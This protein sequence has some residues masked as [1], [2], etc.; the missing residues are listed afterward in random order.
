[1]PHDVPPLDPRCQI[2]CSICICG[3]AIMATCHLYRMG[4]KSRIRLLPYWRDDC[5]TM[6]R[7]ENEKKVSSHCDGLWF[8]GENGAHLGG[9]C[10]R[11]ASS[12]VRWSN[13]TS[14]SAWACTW[15]A[16]RT[17]SVAAVYIPPRSGIKE[18]ILRGPMDWGNALPRMFH[19]SWLPRVHVAYL[20]ADRGRRYDNSPSLLRLID[21]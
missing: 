5:E 6:M 8:E 12:S 13:S 20:G 1:M 21:S 18:G 17:T 10:R 7:A 15:S 2:S 14:A 11:R 9:E 16:S 19:D 4:L 3:H